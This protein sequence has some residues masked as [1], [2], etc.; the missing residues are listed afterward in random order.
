MQIAIRM[1]NRQELTMEMEG[2]GQFHLFLLENLF[3]QKSQ[4]LEGS[5]CVHGFLHS[6]MHIV[7]LKQHQRLIEDQQPVGFRQMARGRGLHVCRV[8]SPQHREIPFD[9]SPGLLQNDTPK[10]A[11]AAG[12]IEKATHGR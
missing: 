12:I 4:A 7:L 1:E 5:D 3:A 6:Q 9:C 8:L 11:Q 10:V 2:I